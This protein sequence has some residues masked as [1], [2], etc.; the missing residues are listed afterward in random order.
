MS[1]RVVDRRT[2]LRE[3][4]ASVFRQKGYDAASLQDVAD[5]MGIQKGSL[6]HYIDGKED[7]LYEIL[8]EAHEG[9]EQANTRWVSME[10]GT[11]ERIHAFVED[12]ARASIRYI[13]YGAVYH[14]DSR[15]LGDARRAH[16][17]AAR[18]RYQA[19]LRTLI[20]DGQ[21]AGAVDARLDPQLATLAVF[22]MVNWLF[23]W[24]RTSGELSADEIAGGLADLAT[25]SLRAT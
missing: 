21:G 25:A 14:R 6:Y 12:H 4:A 19:T 17:Q 24:Y 15:A 8:E 9:V 5:A 10:A 16:I 1:P 23:Q 18:D 13:R 7:L 22:G 3:A 20:E 2:Q 11:L